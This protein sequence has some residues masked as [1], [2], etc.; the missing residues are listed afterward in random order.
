MHSGGLTCNAIVGPAAIVRGT[1]V[2]VEAQFFDSD[3]EVDNPASA[4]ITFEWPSGSTREEASYQ[5]TYDAGL[6][7]WTYAWAS[8]VSDPGTVFWS[9]KAPSSASPQFAQDGAF[10]VNA[11]IANL[12]AA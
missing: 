6:T 3:C 2:V 4:E 5:M 12:V 1:V 10:V 7:K 11:N 9:I 8:Q